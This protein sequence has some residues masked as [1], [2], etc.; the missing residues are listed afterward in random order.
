CS[1]PPPDSVNDDMQVNFGFDSNAPTRA[2]RHTNSISGP[3]ML[4]NS[5]P[6]DCN[7]G[8][9]AAVHDLAL[10]KLDEAVGFLDSSPKPGHPP[11]TAHYPVG[12]GL[13]CGSLVNNENATLTMVGFGPAPSSDG[14]KRNYYGG[15]GWHTEATSSCCATANAYIWEV[16]R[17][18]YYGTYVNGDS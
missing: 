4:R 3:V 17:P 18:F 12:H 11:P 6:A 7:D 16:L 15:P 8:E 13:H 1:A 10:V 9:E 5:N 14:S 2:V